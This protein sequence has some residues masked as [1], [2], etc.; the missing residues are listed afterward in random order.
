MKIFDKFLKHLLVS[1]FPF[2]TL[3][4]HNLHCFFIFGKILL[5]FGI[6]QM[7]FDTHFANN[8]PSSGYTNGVKLDFTPSYL[9]FKRDF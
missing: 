1:N 3:A 5:N 7:N 2:F 4:A 8:W 6:L 9:V